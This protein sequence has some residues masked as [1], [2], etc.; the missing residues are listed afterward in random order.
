M[1]SV[2]SSLTLKSLLK[3]SLALSSRPLATTSNNNAWFFSKDK[4]KSSGHSTLL[5]KD[6]SVY[7]MVTD[8]VIPKEWDSY[9]QHKEKL[10]GCMNSNTDIRGELMGSWSI[11]TG[12]AAFK[13][14][15]LF[16]YEEG[17][18]DIDTTRAAIKADSD[19]QAVYRAGLPAINEQFNELTK[20]FSFWPT[21]DKRE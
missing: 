14:F 18:A 10:V 6:Q 8:T 9:L 13:A 5:S 1:F 19:Y 7:E 3:S 20:G 16:R 15:H 2:M 4:E 21:P 11:V 17:W 12:D